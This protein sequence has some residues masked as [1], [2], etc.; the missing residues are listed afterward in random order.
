MLSDSMVATAGYYFSDVR[1]ASRI[2]DVQGSDLIINLISW[3]FGTEDKD[4]GYNF[5]GLPML[6]ASGDAYTTLYVEMQVSGPNIPLFII[7]ESAKGTQHL[8]LALFPISRL[9]LSMTE[10]SDL[11][12]AAVS[13]K[14]FDQIIQNS[15]LP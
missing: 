6:V 1:L 5:V 7:T 12:A 11:A 8:N 10:S 3:R 4:T 14:V 13:K 2:E 15:S 9:S